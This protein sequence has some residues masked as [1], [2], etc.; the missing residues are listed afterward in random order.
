ME[1]P[2]HINTTLILNEVGCDSILIYDPEHDSYHTIN[3][4][5]KLILDNCTHLSPIELVG[6]F[7]TVFHEA[8]LSDDEILL[9]ITNTIEQFISLGILIQNPGKE[10]SQL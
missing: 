7:R 9:D 1:Y 2:L 3:L 4:T 5:A 6:L 10:D 8:T